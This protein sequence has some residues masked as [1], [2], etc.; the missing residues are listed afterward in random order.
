MMK[1]NT[2]HV[3]TSG[4]HYEHWK[5]PFYPEN[6]P[7][8][9]LLDHYTTHF[10]TVEVNNSFYRLPE[11]KVLK[12]WKENVPDGFVFSVKASR[13]ITHMKKLKDPDEPVATFLNRMSTLEDRLGPVLFQLPP[14]WNMDL[15]RLNSFL[16]A[17]PNEYRYAFEFR[18]PSWFDE[19]TEEALRRK[20]AAF[21]IYSYEGVQSPHSLTA[22][23]VYVRLHGPDHAYR[24]SYDEKALSEWAKACVSWAEEGKEVFCYF[25]NDE[26]GYA[27]QNAL[28]VKEL[29]SEMWPRECG[30]GVDNA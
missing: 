3:G 1:R 28:K 2:I 22:S 4:W 26:A 25:D 10:R 19:K 16:A 11:K 23:F 29:V 24:G 14:K 13:Y 30:E 15:K 9:Q 5:G 17:L 6:L 12:E 18:D 21:C 20:G 8:K 7:D 27:A